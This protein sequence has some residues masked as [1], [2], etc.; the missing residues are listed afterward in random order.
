MQVGISW[1]PWQPSPSSTATVTS[2]NTPTATAS[3]STG[4]TPSQTSTQTGTASSSQTATPSRT[5]T[6]TVLCAAPAASGM[7]VFGR[8]NLLV[9]RVGNGR[10]PVT[11]TAN[12][13]REAFI[14][15]INPISGAL[16]QTL[17]LPTGAASN[18][19]GVIQGGCLVNGAS[20]TMGQLALAADGRSVSM[21]CH[22][23]QPGDS[24]TSTTPKTVYRINPD[25]IRLAGVMTSFLSSTYVYTANTGSPVTS[26]VVTITGDHYFIGTASGP[27]YLAAGTY[28]SAQ[29]ASTTAANALALYDG[30]VSAKLQRQ[31]RNIDYVN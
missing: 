23:G 19:T 24:I 22:P 3:I 4:G 21:V 14:E 26:N 2:S 15:E 31:Q 11:G 7:A 18:A 17:A 20:A 5:A 12:V 9:L 16:V 27:F 1:A 10:D 25:S 8:N 28:G 13:A 30:W 29:Q 6:A